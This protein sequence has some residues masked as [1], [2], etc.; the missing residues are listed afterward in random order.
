MITE[1]KTIIRG[2]DGFFESFTV[3]PFLGLVY[4]RPECNRFAVRENLFF[5]RGFSIRKNEIARSDS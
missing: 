4:L 5:A 2:G 3:V 1:Q